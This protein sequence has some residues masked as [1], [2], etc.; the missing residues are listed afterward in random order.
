MIITVN[1]QCERFEGNRDCCGGCPRECREAF[2]AERTVEKC[3]KYNMKYEGCYY[4]PPCPQNCQVT[5]T[6]SPLVDISPPRMPRLQDGAMLGVKS[7]QET[8]NVVFPSVTCSVQRPHSGENVRPSAKDLLA[9]RTA[10][11][12]PA[13]PNVPTGPYHILDQALTFTLSFSDSFVN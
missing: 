10:V 9:T 12:Q 3:R 8:S 5:P 6:S 7:S 2:A 1:V 11:L 13:L 4:S